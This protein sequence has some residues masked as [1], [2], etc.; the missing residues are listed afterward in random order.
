VKLKKENGVL[1]NRRE[2]DR[3]LI[4]SADDHG[5]SGKR[6]TIRLAGKAIAAE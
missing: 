6:E 5:G 4:A 3:R 2:P 1:L